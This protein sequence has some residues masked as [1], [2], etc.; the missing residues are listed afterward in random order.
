M[1]LHIV[2]DTAADPNS[3]LPVMT[4]EV[5]GTVVINLSPFGIPAVRLGVRGAGDLYFT[6]MQVSS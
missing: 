2:V 5:I 6:G 3:G 4:F 1:Q